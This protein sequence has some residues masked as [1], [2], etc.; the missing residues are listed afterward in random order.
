MSQREVEITIGERKFDVACQEGEEP[1][2]R[3]AAKLLDA[4]AQV[5]LSQIGRMPETRMLLMAGL[6]LAD[7]TAG[8]DEQLRESEERIAQLE[9]QV[10]ELNARPAPDT[11]IVEVPRIPS[12]LSESMAELATRAESLASSIEDKQRGF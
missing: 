6:M 7:K 2:L 11:S 5:L 1:Y 3:H 9:M 4:Q 12:G 10:N 8:L